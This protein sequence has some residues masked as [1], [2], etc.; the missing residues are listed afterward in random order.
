MHALRSRLRN[1]GLIRESR[2]SNSSM[3]HQH[4]TSKGSLFLV[5]LYEAF[6]NSPE[7]KRSLQRMFYCIGKCWGTQILT[8]VDLIVLG[9]PGTLRIFCRGPTLLHPGFRE[10]TH[11]SAGLSRSYTGNFFLA[12]STVIA[13]MSVS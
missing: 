11:H 3:R 7:K 12:T 4:L 1:S 9:F 2:H 6:S 13:I 8:I 10:L 5:T